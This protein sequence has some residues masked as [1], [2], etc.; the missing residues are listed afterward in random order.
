MLQSRAM[1]RRGQRKVTAAEDMRERCHQLLEQNRELQRHLEDTQVRGQPPA[2][3][4]CCTG[5]PRARAAPIR[6]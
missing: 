1:P 3:A 4:H 5:P 6:S 2:A